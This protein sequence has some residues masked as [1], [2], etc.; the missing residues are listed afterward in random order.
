MNGKS[1]SGIRAACLI[2]ICLCLGTAPASASGPDKSAE[3]PDFVLDD[4][5]GSP[6]R[7][8]DFRGKAV[9]INFWATW[10][11]PCVEELPTLEGLR[12]HFQ[13]RPFSVIAV[14]LGED[15]RTVRDFL[16]THALEL[17][18]TFLIDEDGAVAESYR[19]RGLPATLLIDREGR[20]VFG[21]VGQ[22][23]WN[24]PEV[25]SEILPVLE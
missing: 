16:D 24:S 21:G 9:L 25:H 1:V 13:D 14:N 4:L 11:S 17:H 15:A 10:C 18:M 7:L 5:D 2:L 6:V 8:S 19:V 23:D 3:V 20:F 22:R 12:R